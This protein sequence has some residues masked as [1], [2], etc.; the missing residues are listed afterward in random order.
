MI[1]AS[2]IGWLLAP[3]L[4]VS[5]SRFREGGNAVHHFVPH[6]RGKARTDA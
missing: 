4:Y 2:V 1:A 5:I 3:V 6:R